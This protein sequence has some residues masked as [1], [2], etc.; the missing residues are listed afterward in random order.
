MFEA[1]LDA[2]RRAYSGE[3]AKRHVAHIS[4][5][6]RIQASP[7]YRAAAHYVRSQLDAAGLASETISYPANHRTRFWTLES[8]QEWSCSQATLDLLEDGQAVERLCDFQAAPISIIQRSTAAQG[9]YPVVALDNGTEHAHYAGL[10]VA[11]KLVLTDGELG[12]VY[13]LAVLRRGA[14]G[15]LFD[16]MAATAPGRGPLDLPDARQYTSFW[17]GADEPRCFG[18]V[19]TPRQGRRLRQSSSVQVRAAV[20]SQLYDG[21]FEV[22]TAWIPGQTDEEV[23]VVSHL[24]HPQPSANDNA[25]GAAAALEIAATLRRLLDEDALPPPRRGIRFLWMPEMTGT[26][27]YLSNNE[28]RLSKVVAGVNLDMV[29][30]DQA[31]CH[32]VFNIEQPPEAMASFAPVLMKRLWEMLSGDT[33]GHSTMARSNAAVRHAVTSFS[34]GSDHYILSDPTVGVPSPMLIQWP[35]RFYHT[36]ADTLDKVDP[37]MLAHI[38]SL[39]AA[40]AWVIASAHQRT[41][42]WLGHEI[43]ARRQRRLVRR[44]QTAITAALSASDL[45]QLTA[46]RRELRDATAHRVECDM[47]AL[48]SLERLWPDG[49]GLL[50]ELTGELNEAAQRELGR[51]EHVFRACAGELGSDQL[52]EAAAPPTTGGAAWERVPQRLYRG[53]VA[54]LRSLANDDDPAGRDALW[55]ASRRAGALSYTAHSLAEYWADGQRS[56]AEIAEKVYQETGQRFGDEIP[57]YFEQ[58]EAKGLINW[59]AIG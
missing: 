15:I 54:A 36:S 30:Q 28:E 25:S 20:A 6:H 34:G 41:A 18:F 55:Q 51:A 21:A 19:L 46:L 35:D 11:G 43:V 27:A 9:D 38:G 33:G 24:C 48:Q 23:L 52:P 37:A 50:A 8:F 42:T 12:R 39:A 53:P 49:G 5:H 22:V 10:D 1:T 13:D 26:Y 7:G 58:L 57:R 40:Y 4:Q 3:R 16:G 59:R 32:S 44:T 14:A 17:W 47:A 45:E 29:G 31:L 56:L 2:I